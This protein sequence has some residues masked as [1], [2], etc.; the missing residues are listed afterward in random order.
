MKNKKEFAFWLVIAL[1]LAGLFKFDIIDEV[2]GSLSLAFLAAL[3]G[4]IYQMGVSDEAKEKLH[5]TQQKLRQEQ[6]IN[7]NRE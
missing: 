4:F 2:S 7:K 5:Q 3:R 6:L 1:I